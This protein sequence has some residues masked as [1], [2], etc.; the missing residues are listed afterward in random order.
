MGLVEV[1]CTSSW[2][3]FLTTLKEGLNITNTSSFVIMSDK[4]KGSINAVQKIWLDAK[5]KFCVRHLYQNFQKVGHRGEVLKNHL[6]KIAR[7]TNI[8][9]WQINLGKMQVDSNIAYEWVQNLGLEIVPRSNGRSK[10]HTS[11]RAKEL[12]S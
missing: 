6:W 1:E 7:S 3:S 11:W 12:E 5:H 8:V 4:Q 10:A 9:R 2:E